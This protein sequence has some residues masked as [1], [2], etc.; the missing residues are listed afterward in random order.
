MPPT[1]KNHS[2]AAPR[3]RNAWWTW[4]C[5]KCTPLAYDAVTVPD[6]RAEVPTVEFCQFC[7]EDIGYMDRKFRDHMYD[8]E[9]CRSSG[10]TKL[11]SDRVISGILGQQRMEDFV[12]GTVHVYDRTPP[13]VKKQRY[14]EKND[15]TDCAFMA[16]ELTHLREDKGWTQGQLA[17]RLG[18]ANKSGRTS[19]STWEGSKKSPGLGRALE[20]AGLLGR[21]VALVDSDGTEIPVEVAESGRL[22]L[23]RKRRDMGLKE[24]D[25]ARNLGLTWKGFQ[26]REKGSIY[27]LRFA[28]FYDW[29]RVLGFRVALVGMK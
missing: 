5:A 24:V 16:T 1:P 9:M 7:M 8:G 25:A 6:A 29:A 21:K 2:H 20:W 14:F 15:G 10:L 12:G 26:A 4:A 11:T 23:R 3:L 22:V 13:E 19:I 27:H 18:L 17:A 28:D